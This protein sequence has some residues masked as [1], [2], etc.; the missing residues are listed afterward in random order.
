VVDAIPYGY[1]HCGC[2]EKTRISPRTTTRSGHVKGQPFKYL[3]GHN[4]ALKIRYA[5]EDCG[6]ETPCWVWQGTRINHGYG[7]VNRN[8]R[9]TFAHIH[10][11]EKVNGPVPDG[12]E[13]D[14]LCRNPPCCNPAHL[15]AVTHAENM[16]RSPKCIL[17][18]EK[19]A[20]IRRLLPTG[21]AQRVIAERVGVTRGVVRDV[22]TGKSWVGV[23]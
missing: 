15:E 12:L 23:G 6:Y 18:P 8:G 11:W 13:L 17:N 19:V 20:E 21:M 1:C 2:G 3:L 4:H 22:K 10:E 5:E 9:E 14:H 16:R 7:R